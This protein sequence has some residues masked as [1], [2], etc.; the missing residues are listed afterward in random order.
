MV[1][2]KIP[3]R[4]WSKQSKAVFKEA[5]D[6][7]S[8]HISVTARAGTGKTTTI[9]EAA[10]YMPEASIGFA[11][12]NKRI[13][14]EIKT[15][16]KNPRCRV[17][18]LH[19]LGMRLVLSQWPDVTI[20]D[21]VRKRADWLTMQACGGTVPFDVKRM[22][23]KLHTAARERVPH[24]KNMGDIA[25]LIYELEIEPTPQMLDLNYDLEYVESM[26]L[27]AMDIAATTRVVEIDFADQIFLPVRNH[28]TRK[29]MD[30]IIVDERQ[31]MTGPQLA[32]AR[33]V[34][35]GGRMLMVGDDRQAIYGFRGADQEAFARLARELSAK[36]LFLT[37]SYRCGQ[38]IVAEAKRIVPDFEAHPDNPDGE[39]LSASIRDL[40]TMAAP[41]DYILSR[42][43][44]PLADVAMSLLRLN[45]PVRV[46]GRKFGEGLQ[47]LIVKLR[48]SDPSDLLAKINGWADSECDK[49][50]KA[51]RE[52]R[53][54]AVRDRAETLITLAT[55]AV[56]LE[57]LDRRIDLLFSD[58]VTDDQV[59]ICS[60]VHRA[61]GLEADRV[62]ILSDTL[63]ADDLE[64][65]NIQYVAIT[66]ARKTLVYVHGLL[67]PP[68]KKKGRRENPETAPAL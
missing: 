24:A 40:S 65:L 23:S 14:D 58:Q 56:T 41:G 53:I 37:Q 35:A 10:E 7:N 25:D 59:I 46:A 51:E 36:G 39:V 4:V 62:F 21:P 34:S 33:G 29:M 54:P 26:T 27:K 45:K 15:K 63:R 60:S 68:K 66:R 50:L 18:T 8:G 31:D 17:S 20:P 38:L 9:L 57:D 16:N 49:L 47:A 6:P 55:D 12:F 30:A 43:N 22:V 67:N 44:A 48:P 19:G 64:E 32:I 28:W 13:A 61:K 11:A 2:K 1:V 3:Q 5:K 42:T 52:D